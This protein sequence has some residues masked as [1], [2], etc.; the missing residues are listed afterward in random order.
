MLGQKIKKEFREFCVLLK[1]VPPLVVA[2]FIMSVFAMNLLANKSISLPF[3]W[4]ALDCG[5]VVSWFAFFTMDILTK[6]FGPKAATEITVLAIAVNLFFCLLLFIGSVIT[7]VWGESYVEGSESVINAALDNTFGG[8]WY[9][10]V[11]ST[12]AFLVSAVVNNFSNYGIGTL[13]KKNPD[14]MGAY[15]MRSYVSTAV[16]QFVDNLTFA[17]T[18]SHF[19]FGWSVVQCLTCAATGMLVE[20]LCEGVFFYPGFAVT[21]RWK[22]NG[23]GEQYLNLINGGAIDE[24]GDNGNE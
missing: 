17:L 8:T 3:E 19:F 5:I 20:L 2:L 18:V 1:S 16:G 10:V 23:V 15:V 7:G 9:V 24:S 4:L 14:G 6:R 22:N 11:G 12:A 13:F 21:R